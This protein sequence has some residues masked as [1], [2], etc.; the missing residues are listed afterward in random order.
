MFIR[1]FRH[2]TPRA[3]RSFS[4]TG[5]GGNGGGAAT[6]LSAVAIAGSA[7]V[8]YDAS[9]TKEAMEAKINGLTVE[10]AGKTNSGE[11]LFLVLVVRLLRQI[12]VACL[13]RLTSHALPFSRSFRLHQTSCMQGER[14]CCRECCRVQVQGKWYSNY[15]QGSH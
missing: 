2:S 6:F 12:S 9:Q 15:I 3:A 11:F 5:A 8:Y 13:L 4:S 10:L 7:Y 14:R 1:T